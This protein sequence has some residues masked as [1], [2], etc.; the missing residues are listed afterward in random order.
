P[1][2]RA[3]NTGCSP[4]LHGSC[5]RQ[6]QTR[7]Q[8]SEHGL[9]NPISSPATR[10]EDRELP[11]PCQPRRRQ[12]NGER[13][14]QA[15]IK[16]GS[17]SGIPQSQEDAQAIASQTLRHDSAVATSHRAVRKDTSRPAE[18]PSRSQPTQKGGEHPPS[19]PSNP[20]SQHKSQATLDPL[21]RRAR[22]RPVDA[23]PQPV[24]AD[25]GAQAR[26]GDVRAAG[27][28]GGRGARTEI[29][30]AQRQSA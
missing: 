18:P 23:L 19:S 20:R 9:F 4:H 7:D 13:P 30:R 14:V 10:S 27:T 22:S 8:N 11:P 24:R 1:K 2:T 16:N 15:I 5:A 12:S 28:R 17:K 25:V 3:A 29:L 6:N 26:F 21:Q